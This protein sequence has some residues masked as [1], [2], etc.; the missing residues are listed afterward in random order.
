MLEKAKIVFNS[1]LDQVQ[2]K[3]QWKNY[4]CFKIL[5]IKGTS[6]SATPDFLPTRS[7][8]NSIG[9]NFDQIFFLVFIEEKQVVVSKKAENGNCIGWKEKKLVAYKWKNMFQVF[10]YPELS[11]QKVIKR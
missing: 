1:F 8:Q 7:K 6:N 9:W 5:L 4:C 11:C 2:P 10:Y 3:I